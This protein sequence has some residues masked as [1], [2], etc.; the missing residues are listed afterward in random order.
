[1]IDLVERIRGHVR[2]RNQKEKWGFL[3]RTW[4]EAIALAY[5][6]GNLAQLIAPAGARSDLAKMAP[7]ELIAMVLV[8]GPFF[9]TLVFQCLTFEFTTSLPVRRWIRFAFSII[10][11]A[12]AHRFAGFPTVISAGLVGGSYF[13]FT[14]ERWRKESLFIAV[15]MTFLLHS[16]FN[17]VGVLGMLLLPH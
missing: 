11:F 8:I 3:W 7:W 6:V 12:L 4:L 17:L 16:S 2:R 9:E 14:Y 5:L 1:M 10:P 13:A 15:V